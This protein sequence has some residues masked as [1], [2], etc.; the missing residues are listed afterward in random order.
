MLGRDRAKDGP[1]PVAGVMERLDVGATDRERLAQTRVLEFA[2]VGRFAVGS[3]LPLS[4][5]CRGGLLVLRERGAGMGSV[6]DPL[7]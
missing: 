3:T 7:T 5:E 6:S 2:R 4:G 1:D